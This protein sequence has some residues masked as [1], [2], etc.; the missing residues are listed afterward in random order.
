MGLTGV[1]HGLI[2]CM[3]HRSTT[4]RSNGVFLQLRLHSRGCWENGWREASSRRCGKYCKREIQAGRKERKSTR[5]QWCR[6]SRIVSPSSTPIIRSISSSSFVSSRAI[7]APLI[8][9]GIIYSAIDE[10]LENCLKFLWMYRTVQSSSG[11]S[12][13][14]DVRMWSAMNGLQLCEHKYASADWNAVRSNKSINLSFSDLRTVSW[15]T[16]SQIHLDLP[17]HR[18]SDRRMA[19]KN[20][21]SS[22][23][24]WSVSP[25]PKACRL[26]RLTLKFFLW[27]RLKILM[28]MVIIAWI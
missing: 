2:T 11:Q 28:V 20:V 6:S 13:E 10:A 12:T 15:A 25:T 23:T 19:P 3:Q 17:I 22:L 1:W 5:R 7:I 21:S 26:V 4:C 24:K 14:K 9:A 16:L 27:I 18:P 8:I